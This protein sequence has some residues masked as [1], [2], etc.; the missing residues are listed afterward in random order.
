MGRKEFFDKGD[1]L[2]RDNSEFVKERSEK[3]SKFADKKKKKL[4]GRINN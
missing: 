1:K 2:M 4:N 3:I